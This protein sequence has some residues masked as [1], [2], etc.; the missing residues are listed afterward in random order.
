MLR[1]V[2]SPWQALAF[3]T[4]GSAQV[5]ICPIQDM[6]ISAYGVGCSPFFEIPVL[7]GSYDSASCVLTLNL[8][9]GGVLLQHVPKRTLLDRRR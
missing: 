4:H 3:A 8:S 2:S 9:S 6:D 1:R 5:S 7:S